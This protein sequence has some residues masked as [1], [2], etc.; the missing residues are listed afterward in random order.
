MATRRLP[1]YL[2][3]DT[4]G[5]MAGEP[6]EA[7][8]NGIRTLVST[9][10]RDPHALETVHI[11]IIT[12]DRIAKLVVPLTALDELSLPAITTPDSGPTHMGEALELLEKQFKSEVVQ[13]NADTKGDWAPF[14]LVMTDGKASD[15]QLF[16]EVAPRVK[17]LGFKHIVG[18]LAGDD[19]SESDLKEFCDPILRLATMDSAAFDQL[20]TWVSTAVSGE[21]KSLG[22]NKSVELPPPPKE[23]AL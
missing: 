22:T 9:L 3:L 13:N 19:A 21:N 14:A 1:V 4:S 18:C 20:F 16:S 17:K 11:S 7:V 5:S 12:F 6:I 23:I 10:S 8:S 2:V 15:R